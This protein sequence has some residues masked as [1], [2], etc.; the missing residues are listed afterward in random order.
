MR[1]EQGKQILKPKNVFT[2]LELM[3]LNPEHGWSLHITKSLIYSYFLWQNKIALR[4]CN[5]QGNRAIS[6]T[7][8]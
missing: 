1:E 6:D 2:S 4:Y 3:E 5:I 7:L 8:Y